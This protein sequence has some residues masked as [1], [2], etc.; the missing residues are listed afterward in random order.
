MRIWFPFF[1]YFEENIKQEI[2]NEYYAPDIIYE[3]RTMLSRW[4][5]KVRYPID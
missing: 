4:F 2:P 3:I 5:D 1:S